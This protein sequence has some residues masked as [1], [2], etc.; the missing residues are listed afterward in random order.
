MGF[1]QS[2]GNEKPYEKYDTLLIPYADLGYNTAPIRFKFPFSNEMDK[3]YLRNNSTVVL[4]IGFAYKWFNLRLGINLPGNL[5]P[6]YKYGPTDYYDLGF[7]FTFKQ[8]FIDADLHLYQGY[9][10]KNAYKWN[11]TLDAKNNPNLYNSKVGAASLSLNTW[12]F[13]N[14]DFKLSAFRGKTAAYKQDIS[15]FYLKYTISLYGVGANNGLIPIELVDTTQ[16]RTEARTI[17]SFDLGI[18]PGYGYVKRI[19]KWQI[20]AMAGL[21]AVIQAKSYATPEISRG[22]LGLAFRYDVRFVAG[23]NVPHYFLMFVTDFDNKSI[24]FNDLKYRQTYYSIKLAGGYR[25]HKKR[26]KTPKAD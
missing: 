18:I 6:S 4:G 5:R 2:D 10:Y 14:K 17:V 20:G 8:F 21:G 12:H 23:L 26:N 22:F 7:D 15:S 1:T 24:A 19:D 25:F 13:W 11:D 16:T 9:T 3:L